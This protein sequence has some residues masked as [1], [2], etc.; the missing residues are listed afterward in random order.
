MTTKSAILLFG[1]LFSGLA[2]C[3]HT[4]PGGMNGGYYGHDHTGGNGMNGHGTGHNYD[5]LTGKVWRV[6]DIN[7]GG[8][9]DYYSGNLT[10]D[11]QRVSGSTGCNQFGG[12]YTLS[13]NVM[14]FGPLMMSRR[15]CMGALNDLE[16]KF[17]NTLNGD[18][19]IS[20][21]H[22]GALILQSATGAM[23]AR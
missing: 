19:F 14:R 6:E 11:G 18:V 7:S 16:Q 23:L 1:L 22:T 2:A 5:W 20:R 9:I 10:F 15:A 17:L 3:S 8:V 13:G 21:D 4:A 12:T